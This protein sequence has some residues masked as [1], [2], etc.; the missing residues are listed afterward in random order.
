MD[1]IIL[2][3][4]DFM[5][6]LFF[7]LYGVYFGNVFYAPKD[8]ST[9]VRRRTGVSYHRGA[10]IRSVALAIIVLPCMLLVSNNIVVTSLKVLLGLSMFSALLHFA[11]MM[12]SIE[13]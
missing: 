4:V 3:K 1:I 2:R 9:Y 10:A 5:E 11:M 8:E 7:L 6:Y 13:P 12:T